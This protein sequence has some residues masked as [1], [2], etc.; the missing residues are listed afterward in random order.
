MFEVKKII[1]LVLRMINA[2]VSTVEKVCNV[3]SWADPRRSLVFFLLLVLL[4]SVA[5]GYLLRGIGVV[6]CIHRLYKGNS[7][8]RVKHYHNNRKLAIYA[9]RY[10]VNKVFPHLLPSKGAKI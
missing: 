1:E 7:F 4:V 5:S 10:V 2:V 8:Y 9:L 3:F 6:F